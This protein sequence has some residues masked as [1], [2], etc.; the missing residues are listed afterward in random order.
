MGKS[1]AYRGSEGDEKKPYLYTDRERDAAGSEA[2]APR[3]LL[4]LSWKLC[5]LAGTASLREER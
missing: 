4:Y 2:N 5:G 3:H 1:G